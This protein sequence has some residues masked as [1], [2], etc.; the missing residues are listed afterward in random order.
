MAEEK[1]LAG[2][3]GQAAAVKALRAAAARPVHA[4][5]LVGPP[6]TGKLAAAKAFAAMLLCPNG[7][8][9]SCDTCRRVAEGTHPDLTVVEREGAA[10]SIDQAR[11]VTRM[12]ARSAVEGGRALVVLPD[13]HL[14]GDAIP[15][16]LKTIEEPAGPVV[17]VGVADFVPPELVT[18][19]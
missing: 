8:D 15:A 14:A 13:L 19:A 2:L 3:V 4:Y 18:V 9:G 6:G 17:F 10:L 1:G 11:E 5:L 7:G 16:L 12:A